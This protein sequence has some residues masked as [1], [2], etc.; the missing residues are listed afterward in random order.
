MS[1]QNKSKNRGSFG[2]DEESALRDFFQAAGHEHAPSDLSDR[3]I[4]RIKTEKQATLS[5][6]PPLIPTVVWAILGVIC[7]VAVLLTFSSPTPNGG[8]HL[9]EW[10]DDISFSFIQISV[11]DFLSVFAHVP[12]SLAII[13]PFILLQF[14]LIKYFYEGKLIR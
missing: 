9:P 2:H 6:A 12:K 8:L 4:A 3:V 11:S 5:P 1:K 14:V 13:L 7:V 10:L